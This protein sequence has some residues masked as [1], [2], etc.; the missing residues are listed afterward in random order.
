VDKGK[1]YPNNMKGL[2]AGITLYRNHDMAF[3]GL[4]KKSSG[5][6][7][8]AV[9]M[10][11]RR[12]D[13]KISLTVKDEDGNRAETV[14]DITFEP[15]RNP[16]RVIKQIEKQLTSTGNTPYR[17]TGLTVEPD[18]PGFLPASTLN[19]IRREVL[20]KLTA[21]SLKAYPRQK[22]PFVPNDI[23][24]PVKNLDFHANVLNAQARRFYERH[25]AIVAEP[26]FE[27]LSNPTGKEVMTSRYCI[28]HE[29]DLCPKIQRSEKPIQ[30]PLRMRDAHHTYRL[31]FD[32]RQCRMHVIMER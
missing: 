24:Y 14:R 5:D 21:I 10:N 7:R 12:E 18:N 6:R 3:T 17:V 15:S 26:A 11:F 16:L 30:E 32:C 27:T 2:K 23:P 19:G 20:E 8:I 28:R 31:E 13:E 22:I 4:L 25:G 9:T 29:L 1:I